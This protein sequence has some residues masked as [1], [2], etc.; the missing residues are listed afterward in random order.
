MGTVQH[1]LN[2]VE[3]VWSFTDYVLVTL[4]DDD[5]DYSSVEREKVGRREEGG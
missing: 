3:R 5:D 4:N 1:C 2:A